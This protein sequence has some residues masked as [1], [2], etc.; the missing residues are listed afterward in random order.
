MTIFLV[1]NSFDEI[2]GNLLFKNLKFVNA[3]QSYSYN[4]FIIETK[5]LNGLRSLK[6]INSNLINFDL[7][8]EFLLSELPYLFQN[9]IAEVYSFIPS[10]KVKL[11]QNVTFDLSVFSGNLNAIFPDLSLYDGVSFRGVLSAD[12]QVSRIKLNIPKISYKE[13][14]FQNID[15]QLDNQNPFFNTYLTI[16]IINTDVFEIK[17]FITMSKDSKEGLLFRTEFKGGNSAS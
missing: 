3:N 7:Y 9:A 6:T 8:G 4:D 15:F 16:G 12:K 10:R 2:Q 5:F 1:G 11:K 17:E 14:S 13:T